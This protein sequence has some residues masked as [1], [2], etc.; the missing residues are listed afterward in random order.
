MSN[1]VAPG[2]AICAGSEVD[3]LAEK[4][5]DCMSDGHARSVSATFTVPP[6]VPTGTTNGS[7]IDCVPEIISV[8]AIELP[9]SSGTES[10]AVFMLTGGKLGSNDAAVACPAA[11][12]PT[13]ASAIHLFMCSL[14]IGSPDIFL[15]QV[16]AQ[17]LH[18]RTVLG[19]AGLA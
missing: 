18:R 7:T 9:G 1:A 15:V 5:S 16:T 11:S 10:G 14:S 12:S 17:R 4:L 19:P 3:V 6:G 13:H 2:L 8:R